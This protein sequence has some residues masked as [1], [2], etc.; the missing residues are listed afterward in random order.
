MENDLTLFMAIKPN[1][2]DLIYKKIKTLEWRKRISKQLMQHFKD[3]GN[4]NP[5]KIYIYESYPK[6][7][8][9]GYMLVNFAW[10]MNLNVINQFYMNDSKSFGIEL[11]DLYQYFRINRKTAKNEYIGYALNIVDAMRFDKP[12]SLW[13]VDIMYPPQDFIYLTPFDIEKITR[14]VQVYA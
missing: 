6:K 5:V 8:I 10:K 1:Y 14:M 12:I 2:A 7:Y 4:D 9:T 3:Y 13:D 11:E